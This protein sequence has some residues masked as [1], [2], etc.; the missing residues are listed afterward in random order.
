MVEL[1]ERYVF[2]YYFENEI[3]VIFLALSNFF[4]PK[5]WPNFAYI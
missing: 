2:L 3:K 5:F 1:Y 4:R